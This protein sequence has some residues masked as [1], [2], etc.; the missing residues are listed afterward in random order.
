M[1]GLPIGGGGW[2]PEAAEGWG[3]CQGGKLPVPGDEVVTVFCCHGSG[4]LVAMLLVG[5]GGGACCCH[6]GRGPDGG[7]GG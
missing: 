7:G 2:E 4:A 1:D 6:G 3:C 5:G